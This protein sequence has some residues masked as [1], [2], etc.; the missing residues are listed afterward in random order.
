MPRQHKGGSTK[1][2]KRRQKT[3]RTRELIFA[4]DGQ[5]YGRV[6]K[7]LGNGRCSVHLS[8][9]L[10]T[11][12]VIRGK[13]KFRTWVRLDDLVLVSERDYQDGKVDILH[14]YSPE[15][16]RIIMEQENCFNET[17]TAEEEKTMVFE[18]DDI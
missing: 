2:D 15:H 16:A 8:N 17:E 14:V 9:G 6:T 18:F 1:R 7:M 12:G 4:D 5:L 3:P 13:M 10:K 11:L